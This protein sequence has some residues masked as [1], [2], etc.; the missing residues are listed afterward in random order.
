MARSPAKFLRHPGQGPVGPLGGIDSA[1]EMPLSPTPRGWH[2]L[3]YFGSYALVLIRRGWA[4]YEDERGVAARLVPG[5]VVLVL[6]RFG[7]RYRGHADSPE[8]TAHVYACFDGPLPRLWEETGWLHPGVTLLRGAWP[9]ADLAPMVDLLQGRDAAEEL[10]R[11]Q[12][13]LATLLHGRGEAEPRDAWLESA[14]QRLSRDLDQP[15]DLPGV[16]AE[17]GLSYP[18]FRKRFRLAAGVSPGRYRAQ[19]VIAQATQL[20]ATT[21]L[22]DKQI[23]YRLGFANP[24]HFSRRFRQLTG[25]TP[26]ACRER[27]G[28]RGG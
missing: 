10:S 24:Y 4:H 7:H 28:R 5:D 9:G 8:P 21:D 14:R 1:A 18:A 15:L 27:I 19:Q 20:M 3:R 25:E 22:N 13:L 2:G 12:A 11:L 23:A 6:P 26:T 16:A 17:M